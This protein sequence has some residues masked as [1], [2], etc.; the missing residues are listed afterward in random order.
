[1]PKGLFAL[2]SD[3]PHFDGGVYDLQVSSVAEHGLLV[4]PSPKLAL[5]RSWTARQSRRFM[6]GQRQSDRVLVWLKEGKNSGVKS[7]S[8]PCNQ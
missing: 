8:P 4:F 2:V 3:L 6:E 1:M 7:P 5:E